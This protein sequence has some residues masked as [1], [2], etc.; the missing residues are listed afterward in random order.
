M[1][2]ENKSNTGIKVISSLVVVAVII[3]GVFQF[4]RSKEEVTENSNEEQGSNNTPPPP[5]TAQVPLPTPVAETKK[6]KDGT[7]MANGSYISPGGGEK[8]SITL[9]LKDSLVTSASFSSTPSGGTAQRMQ[10]KFAAG[11]K[12]LVVGKNIDEISLTVVNG[13]SLTPVGFMDALAKIKTQA[14]L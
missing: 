4:M 11:F 9:V 12:D 8:V 14:A 10:A 7:Y 13:S 1:E 5:P 2:N 3:F 6:Y